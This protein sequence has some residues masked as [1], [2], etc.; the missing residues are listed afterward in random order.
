MTDQAKRDKQVVINAVVGGD[1]AIL[2]QALTRLSQSDPSKFLRITE[3]L[4]N[5]QQCEQF[6]MLTFSY[7]PEVFHADGVVYGATYTDG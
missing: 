1:L 6:S 3:D 7:M 2:A 5:I 4:L